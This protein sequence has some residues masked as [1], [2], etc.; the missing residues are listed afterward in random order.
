MKFKQILVIKFIRTK[1]KLLA[2]FSQQLAAEKIF[3]LFCTPLV[4][5][6]KTIP[7]F[8]LSAEPLSLSLNNKKV[9]GF[10]WNKGQGKRIMILHGFSSSAYKF[11]SYIGAFADKGYEV[12]AFNAPAHGNSEGK[13]VNVLEYSELIELAVQHFGM[14]DGFIAHSFGGIALALAMENIPHAID[15]RIVFIAPATETTTAADEAF[16]ILNIKS[17]GLRAAFDKVIFEKSGRSISWFSIRRA[18]NQILAKVLWVHD[19]NDDIT[20]LADALKVK[21]DNHPNTQFIVTSGLGHRNIYHNAEVKK[22]VF[23]FLNFT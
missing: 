15:T 7:A 16:K 18:M 19:K 23:D 12:L 11:H 13:T 3:Q 2:M 17:T 1:F 21:A 4:K 6:E 10:C 9:N 8:F 20:P 22:Q 14:P 5:P